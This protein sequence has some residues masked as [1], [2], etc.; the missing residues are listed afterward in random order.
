[1]RFEPCI[2]SRNLNFVALQDTNKNL[3]YYLQH[4]MIVEFCNTT[5]QEMKNM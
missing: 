3:I 4:Q 5:E 1:M 2:Y